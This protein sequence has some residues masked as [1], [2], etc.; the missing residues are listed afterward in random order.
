MPLSDGVEHETRRYGRAAGLLSAGIA[1]GGLLIYAYFGLASHTLTAE[2]YG[3]LVV[4]WLAVVVIVSI[5]F[6]PI[7]QLLARTVAEARARNAADGHAIR[8]AAAIALGLAAAFVGF[9]FAARGPIEDELPRAR[10]R[11]STC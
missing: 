6:R 7:E 1:L 10:R 3:D 5:L 8:V 2:E 4:L 11:C 9:A